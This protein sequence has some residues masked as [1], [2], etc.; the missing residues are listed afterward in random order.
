ML[1]SILLFM[2]L[3]LSGCNSLWSV[4]NENSM[5]ASVIEEVSIQNNTV[6]EPVHQQEE[7]SGNT[8]GAVNE[9][10]SSDGESAE[11]GEEPE[12]ELQQEETGKDKKA[13]DASQEQEIK[14]PAKGQGEEVKTQISKEPATENLQM[15]AEIKG[16]DTVDVEVPAGNWLLKRIWWEKAKDKFNKIR[17]AVNQI[18]DAPMKFFIQQNE[19]EKNTLDKFYREIGLEQGELQE[20]IKTLI[21]KIDYQREKEGSL[22]FEERDI[23]QNL[24]DKQK[25][26]EQ[27]D[28]DATAVNEFDIKLDDALTLLLK[29]IS[30]ARSYENQAWEY[31]DA[32]AHELSDQ[33]AQELYYNMD[34]LLKDIRKISEYIQK[35]FAHYF[36]NMVETAENQISRIKEIIEELSEAGID[37]KMQL[38]GLSDPVEKKH[39]SEQ[40]IRDVKKSSKV[41]P[42]GWFSRFWSWITGSD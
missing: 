5:N 36:N 33:R 32:I 3:L 30:Q 20:V 41:E 17:L 40:E 38:E 2:G 21:D 10:S 35:D 42:R 8:D 26:L 29:Q 9:L 11:K 23:L 19:F 37:L 25:M 1:K 24:I 27:L 13:S 14:T 22:D 39:D 16:I 28:K 6:E 31:F 15:P 4:E 18:A 34:A 12:V 7:A